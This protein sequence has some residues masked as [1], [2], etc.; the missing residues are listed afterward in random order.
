MESNHKEVK[1]KKNYI[2]TNKKNPPR[3]VMSTILGIIS[4]A[5]IVIVIA[6]TFRA[7]GVAKRQYGTSVLLAL[8]FSMVG[9]VLGVLSKMEKEM[10]Y[11]FSYLGIVLNLLAIG[12][13]SFILYAGAYGL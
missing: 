13:I 1:K 8:I 5:A 4:I 9:V 3:A 11:F 2:F 7:D 10:F 6:L 12:A